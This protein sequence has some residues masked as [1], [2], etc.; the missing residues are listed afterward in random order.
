[1]VARR[2]KIDMTRSALRLFSPRQAASAVSKGATGQG[3]HAA[4]RAQARSNVR[5]PRAVADGLHGGSRVLA[6]HLSVLG[7]HIFPSSGFMLR[8]SNPIES[9]ASIRYDARRAC[10]VHEHYSP[11]VGRQGSLPSLGSPRVA[12]SP[13][14]FFSAILR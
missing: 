2:Q 5:L 7:I 8:A 13:S 12:D 3:V 9:R 14:H 1:M 11:D 10:P 4:E 6:G